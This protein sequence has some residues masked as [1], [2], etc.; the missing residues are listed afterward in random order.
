MHTCK[1]VDLVCSLVDDAEALLPLLRSWRLSTALLLFYW[2]P[3]DLS[4]QVLDHDIWLQGDGAM[5]T[6]AVQRKKTGQQPETDIPWSVSAP[7]DPDE[8]EHQ[9]P[10]DQMSERSADEMEFVPYCVMP[11]VERLL[12]VYPP[13]VAKLS[14]FA[15]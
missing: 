6:A 1:H 10:S 2:F 5:A 11:Y 9:E 7:Y 4:G 12:Q 3:E 14:S 13:T 15:P 8:P